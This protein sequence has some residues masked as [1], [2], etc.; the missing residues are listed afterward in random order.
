MKGRK[1]RMVD[2]LF[3]KGGIQSEHGE[4]ETGEVIRPPGERGD[5]SFEAEGELR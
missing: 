2:V 5:S 1:R 4:G 3:D